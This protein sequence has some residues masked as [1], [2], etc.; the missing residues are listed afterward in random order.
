MAIL[1]HW[2]PVLLSEELGRKPVSVRL[3]GKP[4]VLFRTPQGIGALDDVCP[5]RRMRLS[6]GSVVGDRLRCKYHGWSFDTYGNGESPGT[7][8]L[9]ACAGNYTAREAHGAVWLKSAASDPPFP[10]FTSDGFSLMCRLRHTIPAPL[11]LTM[12][13]FCEIEHTP[14]THAVFG[15]PLERMHEVKVDVTADDQCVRVD[16]IGPPKGMPLWLRFLLGIRKNYVFN[17]H[18]DTYFSPCYGIFQHWWSDP[19][20]GREGLVRWRNYHF[21]WPID[22]QNTTLVTWNFARS[23]WPGPGGYL[24]AFRWLMRVML[25]QELQLDVNILKGLASYDPSIDG[26]KLSRFDKVLGL[27]RERI[28]RIYRGIGEVPAEK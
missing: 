27:N 28:N 15:Y 6:W 21:W 14:T 23:S 24:W 17:D 9:H 25:D 4:L 8:K 7:P 19:V 2:H 10:D 5:H 13:N 26:M 16:N 11:E 3:A 18:W 12:D 20:T 1:D 22:D